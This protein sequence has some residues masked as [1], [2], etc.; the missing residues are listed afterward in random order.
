MNNYVSGSICQEGIIKTV[1]CAEKGRK[2]VLKNE[3]GQYTQKIHVDG[4]LVTVGSRC[5]Y[6]VDIAHGDTVYLVELKG[7]DKEHAFEQLY[8]SLGYFRDNY[9]TDKYYCRAVL[10]KDAAPKLTGKYEKLLIKAGKERKCINYDYACVIYEKD[11][12]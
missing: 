2:F 7:N 11:R 8:N 4:K 5:D 10:S 6:A 12:I 1:V 9:Q 3:S